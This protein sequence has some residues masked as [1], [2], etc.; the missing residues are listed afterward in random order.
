MRVIMLF[1]PRA[2]AKGL[3]VSL[4]AGAVLLLAVDY[5]DAKRGGGGGGRGGGIGGGGGGFG[6]GGFHHRPS[7][8]GSYHRPGGGFDGG[9]HIDNSLPGR[10]G[11]GRPDRPGDG[12]PNRP[13]GGGDNDKP[14]NGGSQKPG[15]GYH[16]DDYYYGW[17][18]PTY[19]YT[20]MAVGAYVHSV[21]TNCV[22]EEYNGV[23]Y[24]RCGDVW[25][26]PRYE[27]VGVR[28]VVVERPF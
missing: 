12:R 4:L 19:G 22:Y 25:Y 13:G 26:E 15:G 8:G 6:G 16:Y 5:C 10:P 18:D 27:D 24:R 7:G 2:I 23:T 3:A 9:A 1:E 11:D 17:D 20:G 21:P 14:N 28:Y